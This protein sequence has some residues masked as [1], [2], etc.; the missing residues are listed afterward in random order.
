MSE[1]TK[2]RREIVFLYSVKDANPNGDPDDDNRPRTDSEGYNIVS[3]VRLKR[4]IRD[5]LMSQKIDILIRREFM[6]QNDIMEMEDLIKKALGENITRQSITLDLP[7]KF[8][9]VRLFGATAVVQGANT[10]I[11]GPVQFAIG[12]SLNIPNIST[13]AITSTM[14]AGKTTG[15]AMGSFHILDYSLLA[16][17]GVICP[18]L[19]EKTELTEKDITLLFK[20]MWW[21]TKTLNTRTKFNHLPLLLLIFKS[22]TNEFLIGDLAYR[23]K[24]VGNSPNFTIIL[25]D[26]IDRIIEFKI[27]DDKKNITHPI[28]EVEYYQDPQ[29][30]LGYKDQRSQSFGEIWPADLELITL[31]KLSL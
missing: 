29:V 23:L 9:D 27:S 3:D 14:A 17:E 21:G 24:I 30:K 5:Y 26:L 4:T 7:A 16:F 20:A 8:M 22:K 15:G 13:H 18:N 2:N 12:R 28:I 6:N 31:K 11:T 25:D 10:S 1:T 19:A